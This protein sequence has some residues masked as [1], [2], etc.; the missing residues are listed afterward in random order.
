MEK[1]WKCY[2][3]VVKLSLTVKLTWLENCFI[4]ADS[5]DGQVSTLVILSGTNDISSFKWY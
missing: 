3:L 2:Q 5:V 4:I 1:P